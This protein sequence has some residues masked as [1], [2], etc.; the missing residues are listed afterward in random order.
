MDGS[1]QSAPCRTGHQQAS[2]RQTTLACNWDLDG[3]L[4]SP[5]FL[6][7]LLSFAQRFARDASDDDHHG[8]RRQQAD[9]FQC[10]LEEIGRSSRI[11]RQGV[12]RRS[13]DID[14]EKYAR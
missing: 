2:S 11:A 3:A 13:A 12:S 14:V 9:V 6:L 8:D 5:S 7:D 1:S 4:L 10:Q